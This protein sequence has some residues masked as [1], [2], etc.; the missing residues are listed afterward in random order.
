MKKNTP[1]LVFCA[2]AL[3][4]IAIFLCQSLGSGSS[5]LPAAP[6]PAAAGG[7]SA[8]APS[9]EYLSLGSAVL[10][11]SGQAPD[12]KM[13]IETPVMNGSQDPHVVAFNKAISA[14]VQQ[15]VE[16]F[17]SSLKD[18]PAKAVGTGSTFDLKSVPVSQSGH[19]VSLQLKIDEYMDGA[20]HPFSYTVA[21]NYDLTEEKEVDL[22]QLFLPGTD[23]LQAISDYCKTELAKRD[24]GFDAQQHGADPKTENYRSWNIGPQAL[25]IT[26]DEYQ[27]APYAAGP[28]VVFVPYTALKSIIDPN[29]PLQQF[30]P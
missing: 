27:V 17:K 28:Q 12:Y 2:V 23:Y 15:Q 11:Q 13:T 26:F 3:L 22:A 16:A 10:S 21:Y 5:T 29:G 7:T 1:F 8:T 9:R 6:K 20:A 24:I 14:A 19:I 30:K 4:G 18:L 25:V